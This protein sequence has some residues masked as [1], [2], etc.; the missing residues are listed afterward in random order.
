MC[1]CGKFIAYTPSHIHEIEPPAGLEPGAKTPSAHEIAQLKN[2]NHLSRRFRSPAVLAA[3]TVLAI[4]AT[5]IR[6]I[7]GSVFRETRSRD[8]KN[9]ESRNAENC[10][11]RRIALDLRKRQKNREVAKPKY[12]I[13]EKVAD[14]RAA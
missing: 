11:R 1:K 7:G 3:H 6:E 9:G 14:I 5:S 12:R 13:G 4:I 2:T 8:L 10:G